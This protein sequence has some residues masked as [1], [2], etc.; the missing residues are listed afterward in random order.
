MFSIDVL[1]NC[2]FQYSTK[3]TIEEIQRRSTG[4]KIECVIIC[5]G[6]SK[7]AQFVQSHANAFGLQVLLPEETESVPFGSAMLAASASRL[8]PDLKTAAMGMAGQARQVNAEPGVK[9]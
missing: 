4:T 6:L 3:H 9:K 7:N 5:G 1:R 2:F 8:Y